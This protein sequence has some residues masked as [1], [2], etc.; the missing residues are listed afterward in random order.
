MVLN[1]IFFSNIATVASTVVGKPPVKN[2]PQLAAIGCK[3][4]N[5]LNSTADKILNTG[6]KPA[7]S[8][9]IHPL[10]MTDHSDSDVVLLKDQLE[11]I[12][13]LT[14]DINKTVDEIIS[15]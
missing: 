10:V 9:I 5:R 11:F 15:G 3:A 4:L 1:H 12:E 14:E 13:R 7:E 8:R 6:R 2:A